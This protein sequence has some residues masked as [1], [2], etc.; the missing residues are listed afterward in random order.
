MRSRMTT[1]K[2][3]AVKDLGEDS[4]KLH[5]KLDTSSTAS[6]V[7][8]LHIHKRGDDLKYKIVKIS[9]KQDSNGFPVEFSSGFGFGVFGEW[10]EILPEPYKPRRR[11]FAELVEK[12]L[13]ALSRAAAAIRAMLLRRIERLRGK[14][15]N[16]AVLPVLL[17]AFCAAGIVMLVSLGIIGYKL[18][19]VDLF[20]SYTTVSVPDLV[21]SLYS[22][23]DQR[24]DS[25]I[26]DVS[27]S[28]K[29]DPDSPRGTV[30]SQTPR[31]GVERRVY[32]NRSN[33]SLSLVVSLGK[34]THSIPD[35]C[36]LS[37]RDASLE[38]KNSGVRFTVVEEYSSDI[39]KGK[40]IAS[41]P[42]PNTD[43]T[44]DTAVTLKVSLGKKTVYASVP[45]LV[46]LTESRAASLLRASGLNIGKITYES[47][48]LPYGTVISQ[49]HS[50]YSELA[51]GEAVGFTVS[52]GIKY[53]EKKI[54]SLYGFT[55]DEARARLAELGLVLGNIY[56]VA[57]AAP[58]GTVV[59]QS[60]LPETP[61]TAEIYS[62]DIYVSS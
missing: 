46:G 30:L 29:Y 20:S 13:S 60:V 37:L 56:A 14:R 55:I 25:R 49:T 62:V 23:D 21:G 28:Y 5:I 24:L 41:D 36:G 57:N 47:S 9:K 53:N 35:L 26:Y 38:L 1:R 11:L 45:S 48:S 3:V 10:K 43:F 61:V 12:M 15:E 7:P 58:S 31:A 8:P 33:S 42:L 2:T 17:G 39:Q 19:L 44:E 40:V 34:K 59:A 51:L 22:E 18:I 27:V 52:A 32:K 6:A 50:A 4:V 54:P 16:K